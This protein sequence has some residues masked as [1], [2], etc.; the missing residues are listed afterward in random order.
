LEFVFDL[1][2]PVS[3]H[4]RVYGSFPSVH[5]S[6]HI[7]VDGSLLEGSVWGNGGFGPAIKA[8]VR[9]DGED[10]TKANPHDVDRGALR[11]M[12]NADIATWKQTN[13]YACFE[14]LKTNSV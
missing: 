7:S 8:F 3:V 13:P 9:D 1:Y 12:L 14:V 5:I 4:I 11:D 6:V 2:H 10:P